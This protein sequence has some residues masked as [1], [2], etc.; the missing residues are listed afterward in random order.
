MAKRTEN[1]PIQEDRHRI[2]RILWFLYCFF[3]VASL[4][5]ICRIV[6]IQFFWEPDS[7]TVSYFQPK[8]YS[9]RTKP[10]RGSIMDMNGKLLA[11]STPMYNI[12]MD[13]TILKEDFRIG[14]TARETDSLE[15][16][17]S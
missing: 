8:K 2:S 5:L 16:H 9:S 4:V 6:Q 10:E 13:C 15:R 11:I 12:N 17:M 3:L 14:H 7:Q 1:T